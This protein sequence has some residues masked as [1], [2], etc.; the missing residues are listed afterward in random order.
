MIWSFSILIVN[1]NVIFS[2]YMQNRLLFIRIFE[3]SNDTESEI[4]IKKT[5]ETEIGMEMESLCYK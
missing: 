2:Y 5:M 1:L 3:S 4:E